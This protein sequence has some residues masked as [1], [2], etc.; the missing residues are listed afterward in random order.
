MSRNGATVYSS[1]H[2]RMCPHCGLP[3]KRCV[4]RANP[5]GNAAAVPEETDGIVRIRREKKG[6]GGKVVT[7]ASGIPLPAAELRDLA[8]QLRRSCGSGG[9]VKQGVVEIQGDHLETLL[10][11]LGERGYRV[12]HSGG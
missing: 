10:A 3:Q 4:C 1:Q 12:K 9:T 5:R 2:G 7:T 11:L 8:K 6:R